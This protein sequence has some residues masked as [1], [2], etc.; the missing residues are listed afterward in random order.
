M[1]SDILTTPWWLLINDS[2]LVSYP[3][4][5][6]STFASQLTGSKTAKALI[7][8]DDGDE[9]GGD[10]RGERPEEGAIEGREGGD[11]M[12]ANL[13]FTSMMTPVTC[14]YSNALSIIKGSPLS[15]GTLE[16]ISFCSFSTEIMGKQACD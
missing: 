4:N 14:K 15:I 2:L 5:T 10:E 1:M 16:A 3:I 13:W 7:L 12:V 11:G 6:L 9:D 8:G